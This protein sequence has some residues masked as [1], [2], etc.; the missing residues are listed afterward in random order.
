MTVSSGLMTTQAPIS[1]VE[2]CAAAFCGPNGRAK[3]T[4]SPPL[5]AADVTMNERRFR[6]AM[7][8]MIASPSRVRGHV[9]GF[10]HLL[11]GAAAAYVGDRNIDVVVSRFR[12]LVEERRDSHDHSALAVAAL[13]NVVIDPRLL[14]LVQHAVLRQA[15]D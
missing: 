9:N 1:G 15:L 4:A 3:P 7:E 8:F 6:F 5:A 11:E 12:L 2:F 14:Y 10:A 13:R